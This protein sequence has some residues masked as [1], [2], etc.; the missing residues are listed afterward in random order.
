M[1]PNFQTYIGYDPETNEYKIG[2]SRNAQ[3]REGTIRRG[4]DRQLYRMLYVSD[5]NCESIIHS[6]FKG[7]RTQGEWFKLNS[8][9]LSVLL[10]NFNFYEFKASLLPQVRST[11]EYIDRTQAL[12]LLGCGQD[13]FYRLHSK[14]L[15][16]VARKRQQALYSKQQV[17]DY[18]Q[19]VNPPMIIVHL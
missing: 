11:E 14:N 7:K 5:G 3:E 8:N 9:D 13:S 16:I 18:A 17:S 6:F 19:I 2:K 1:K 15:P 10:E 12:M 4:Y